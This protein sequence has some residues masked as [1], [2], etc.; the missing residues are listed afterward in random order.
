MKGIALGGGHHAD[1]C[2]K[3]RLRQV[4]RRVGKQHSVQTTKW[5][6]DFHDASTK[7]LLERLILPKKQDKNHSPLT[8]TYQ[9]VASLFTRRRNQRLA[10]R[11]PG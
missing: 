10:D 8:Q 1:S 5:S 9:L 4:S 7:I 6:T 3:I 2:V 11:N